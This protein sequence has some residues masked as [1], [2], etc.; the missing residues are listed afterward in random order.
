MYVSLIGIQFISFE[1]L[2]SFHEEDVPY[3]DWEVVGYF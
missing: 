3:Y 2:C 1:S